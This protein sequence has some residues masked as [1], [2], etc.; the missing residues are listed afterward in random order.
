MELVLHAYGDISF[1]IRLPKV[2][3]TERR[4]TMSPIQDTPLSYGFYTASQIVEGTDKGV[5]A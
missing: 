5:L 2:A 1:V 3:D 4:K